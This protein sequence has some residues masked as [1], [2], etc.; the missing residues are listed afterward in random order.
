MARRPSAGLSR[1]R[2]LIA[3]ACALLA[4]ACGQPLF[5]ADPPRPPTI[6]REPYFAPPASAAGIMAIGW[7]RGYCLGTCPVYSASLYASGEAR[8]R[9]SYPEQYRGGDTT[10]VD[11]AT[12]TRL[13]EQLFNSD[14]FE[15]EEAQ[16][17][18]PDIPVLTVAVTLTDGRI[19][20]VSGTHGPQVILVWTLDSLAQTLVWRRE[21][22]PFEYY[23]RAMVW[24][25][26]QK[27]GKDAPSPYAPTRIP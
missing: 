21:S 9:G 20:R 7:G 26:Q 17:V 11:S 15:W 8:W 4:L 13:A 27:A 2:A 24:R 6:P 16:K 12:F 25:S 10:T 1:S 23:H 19:K 3:P 22:R 14:F 18:E 5:V